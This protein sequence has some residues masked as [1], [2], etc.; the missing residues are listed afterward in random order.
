MMGMD[1]DYVH[2]NYVKNEPDAENEKDKEKYFM[3][4]FTTTQG[5]IEGTVNDFWR[6]VVQE[7]VG[8]IFMLCS[9]VELGKKKCEVYYPDTLKETVSYLGKER[10]RENGTM[11]W[12][13]I[14]HC[15]RYQSNIGRSTRRWTFH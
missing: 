9:I 15:C 1:G 2:A 10:E 12:N 11:K 4:D 7:N 5:P 8:Y 13:V 14:V 6:L 3:N